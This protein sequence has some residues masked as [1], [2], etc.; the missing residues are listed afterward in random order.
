VAVVVVVDAGVEAGCVSVVARV[1]L[2]VVSSEPPQPAATRA[3]A[4][5]RAKASASDLI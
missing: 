3:S 1:E 4:N 5:A 2:V